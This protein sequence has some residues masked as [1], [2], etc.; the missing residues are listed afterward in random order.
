MRCRLLGLFQRAAIGE[1]SG[2]PRRPALLSGSRLLLMKG[3]R[4][5]GRTQGLCLECLAGLRV[6]AN[7]GSPR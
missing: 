3:I 6:S 5:R 4:T 1:I 7:R 2:D